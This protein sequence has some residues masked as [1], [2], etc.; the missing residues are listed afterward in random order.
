[1]SMIT[2]GWRG[3]GR[4]IGDSLYTW[5]FA[6]FYCVALIALI[7]L[8][9]IISA[10]I[11][12]LASGGLIGAIEAIVE[13]YAVL[14]DAIVAIS[15]IVLWLLAALVLIGPIL[16]TGAILVYIIDILIN[17]V[18]NLFTPGVST[19]RRFWSDLYYNGK[20]F[21]EGFISSAKGWSA[22]AK[23]TVQRGWSLV[24]EGAGYVAGWLKSKWP[25]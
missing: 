3:I 19:W 13:T 18:S 9:L 14:V 12:G 24:K 7:C 25:F 22:K 20:Y 15:G 21:T 6:I 1:M 2:T 11:A 4:W 17:V 10:G 5:F 23:A 8:V 16:V